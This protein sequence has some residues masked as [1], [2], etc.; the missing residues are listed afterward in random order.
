MSVLLWVE[1]KFLMGYDIVMKFFFFVNS[2]DTPY[3]TAIEKPQNKK[4]GK[5]YVSFL[6]IHETESYP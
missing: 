5:F 6:Y 3:R 1:V 2:Q 4:C